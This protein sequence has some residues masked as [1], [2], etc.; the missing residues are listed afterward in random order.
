MLQSRHPETAR[1]PDPRLKPEANVDDI[2]GVY[3]W[4]DP[5]GV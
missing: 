1:T 5:E 4:A 2:Y 3:F